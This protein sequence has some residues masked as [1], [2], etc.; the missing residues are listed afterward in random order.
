ML[1]GHERSFSVFSLISHSNF[2]LSLRRIASGAFE[3]ARKCVALLLVYAT[4]AATMPVRANEVDNASQPRSTTISIVDK[5]ILGNDS[6]KV[7]D[8]P[9]LPTSR[10]FIDQ[11][12][13]GDKPTLTLS[14]SQVR[15]HASSSIVSHAAPATGQ[16]RKKSHQMAQPL[17]TAP[18]CLYALDA[19]AQAAF[20]ISGSTSISTSCSVAVESSASQ[21]FQ[22]SGTET[23]DLQNNAQVGV[24]GGWNLSGQ[25]KIVNQSTGQSVS[26]VKI[27]SPGDPLSFLPIPSGGTIIGKTHTSYD[28]NNKPPNNT[29]S[30]GI[31]CGGLTIGNTNGATFTMSPGTYIMAGGGLTINSLA[32]VSGSGVTVYNTSSTGWGCSGS[33][34]YTPITISGQANVTISAPSTGAL[35]NVLLFGDRAGC[36]KAG[37][38]EDQINGSSSTAFNGALYFKTDTLL[39]TGSNSNGCMMAVADMLT[40]NGNTS[41]GING[42]SGTMGGVS[43]SVSPT[44][45]TLYA[46]QTQQFS[47]TVLNTSNMAVTWSI[48]PS[49]GTI[50]SSG[51]YTAPS[52]ITSQQTV[53]VTA[54]SQAEPTVSGSATVT[55]MPPVSV[56]ISPTAATL[57]GGQTQQFS[58]AVSNTTNPAVTWSVN[59]TS[60]G[61]ITSAG[62]YTAPANITT[63]QSVVITATSQ[64][65]TSASASA[66]VTLSPPVTVSVT[67][68][69]ATLYPG[70]SQQFSASVGNYK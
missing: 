4:M 22:M 16:T 29:L 55:L 5:S 70:Q 69:S 6:V 27:S 14:Q 65:N 13:A 58:S 19:S 59:P 32:V 25:T 10:P 23:L 63:Q 40:F 35:A 67:P 21:A 9:G 39:F 66:T 28:M 42:C 11:D 33:S 54:T 50:N 60:V 56:S 68:T 38:C 37:N 8:G 57:Y 47:A 31:Y 49:V 30:A 53:T 41:F 43:V 18:N 17:T 1:S 45:A 52:S 44:T 7:S 26:P 34:S 64:A 24:V 20:S 61:T 15:S 12:K 2:N 3:W 51:L 36:S 46:A 62:L 48:S